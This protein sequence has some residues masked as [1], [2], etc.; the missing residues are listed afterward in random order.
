MQEK[1]NFMSTNF[2]SLNECWECST[3]DTHA[4]AESDRDELDPRRESTLWRLFSS[5][6]S[7]QNVFVFYLPATWSDADLYRLFSPFGE[8]LS[9]KV[10]RKCNQASRGYGFVAYS[11]EAAARR[12]V[13]EM[14]GAS[15]GYKRLRVT[16]KRPNTECSLVGGRRSHHPDGS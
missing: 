2:M 4:P 5:H 13:A 16:L 9:A 3:A 12:A 14:N 10:A 8:I 7:N 1:T 6:F 11:N 15:A